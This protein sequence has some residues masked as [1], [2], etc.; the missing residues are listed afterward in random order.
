[1]NR[2]IGQ[3]CPGAKTSACWVNPPEHNAEFVA[4]MEDVLEVY[5]RSY[6]PQ[7]PVVCLD[8]QPTQVI[9]ETH[10]PIPA[11]SGQSQR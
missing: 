5:R 2:S 3:F 8:E 11:Q 7:R 6:D 10:T 1:M 9:G 4:G